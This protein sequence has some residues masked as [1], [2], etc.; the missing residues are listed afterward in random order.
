MFGNEDASASN[1]NSLNLANLQ[2]LKSKFAEEMIETTDAYPTIA[3]STTVEPDQPRN[4]ER[5]AAAPQARQ[6]WL[7]TEMSYDDTTTIIEDVEELQK[8]DR[9]NRDIRDRDQS[10][11]GECFVFP[12][13]NFLSCIYVL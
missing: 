5:L 13:L 1:L 10:L 4:T 12:L 9:D 11:S 6:A 2:Q 3:S 7:E 8:V